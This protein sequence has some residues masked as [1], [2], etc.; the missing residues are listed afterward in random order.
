[1]LFAKKLPASLSIFFG[2]S[3]EDDLNIAW[4]VSF[5]LTGVVGGFKGSFF[6]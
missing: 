5:T 2:N 3:R 1:M 6:N 4:N